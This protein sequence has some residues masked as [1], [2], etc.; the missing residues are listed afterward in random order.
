MPLTE[1]D[2]RILRIRLVND[3]SESKVVFALFQRGSM[4]QFSVSQHGCSIAP[5]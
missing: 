5:S 2:V 1:P 4:A 3:T